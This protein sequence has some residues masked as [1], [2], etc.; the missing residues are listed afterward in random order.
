MVLGART[1]RV[2]VADDSEA[3]RA[4]VRALVSI[5]SDMEF[6]GAA[7]DGPAALA[8]VAETEPDVLVLDLAMPRLN[9]L[10][11]LARLRNSDCA[12]KT[13]VYSSYEEPD[14]A[15]AAYELGAADCLV[16]G[17]SLTALIESLRVAGRSLRA[18]STEL[19]EDPSP[20]GV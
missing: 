16:K 12:T 8:L 1:I 3:V 17:V 20:A 13:V 2:V 18:S 14:S 10:S 9:G 6:V 19:L 5:E 4:L 11:V 15:R 7:A